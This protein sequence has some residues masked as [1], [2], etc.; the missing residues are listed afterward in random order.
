MI[1]VDAS[2]I[3]ELLLQTPLGMLVERRLYR[4]DEDMHAPHLIDV[5]ILSALRRLV[6]SGE[7]GPDRAN[8]AIADLGLLRIVRHSHV[9][10]LERAWQLRH[11]LTAYDAMYVAVAEALDAT[12]VTC[13]GALSAVSRHSSA[14]IELITLAR[15]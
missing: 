3:A 7:V 8:D 4:M 6:A 9:D 1:A 10:L 11:S 15:R 5:E 14:R 12:L 13:D 2:A